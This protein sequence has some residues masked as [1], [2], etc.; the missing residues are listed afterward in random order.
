MSLKEEDRSGSQSV[1]LQNEKGLGIF[2]TILVCTLIGILIGIAIPYYQKLV[3]EAREV[4]LRSGLVNVRK[5]VEL[6]HALQGHYPADLKNL[7]RRRYV[8]ETRKDT[9]F[10]GEYLSA[11]SSDAEGY[12]LD[13]F[14]NRYLYDP[15]RGH[16]T[17]T[18]KGYETW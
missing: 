11:V 18:T 9:F 4:A 15:V 17:S 7:A 13:S 1:R 2:D 8:V 14:G 12:L 6:Y 10:S 5:G 3:K 16:V